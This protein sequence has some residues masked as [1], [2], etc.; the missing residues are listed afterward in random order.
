MA[1]PLSVFHA[2]IRDAEFQHFGPQFGDGGTAWTR[3][4]TGGNGISG[5][6][7]QSGPAITINGFMRQ[8]KR[9]A[10]TGSAPDVGVVDSVWLFVGALGVDVQPGDTLVSQA[11]PSLA[12]VLGGVLETVGYVRLFAE[13]MTTG[14][15]GG[16]GTPT[17]GD[18]LAT[19][20]GDYLAGEP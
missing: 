15:S 9:S 10:I 13:Q 4:R 1:A 6:V 5:P 18:Y 16:G 3:T 12:F 17:G 19:E 7:A 20:S 8:A 2:A 11:E 14:E